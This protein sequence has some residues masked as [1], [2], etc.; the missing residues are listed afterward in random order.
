MASVV[1]PLCSVRVNLRF[2][3]AHIDSN[4]ALHAIAMSSKQSRSQS[5]LRQYFSAK[6]RKR[7]TAIDEQ[8][9]PPRKRFKKQK[10]FA[11]TLQSFE[12]Q[13]D[14]C[15]RLS[16]CD[17]S[18]DSMTAQCVFVDVR[19]VGQKF[20]S[21]KSFGTEQSDDDAKASDSSSDSLSL[22]HEADNKFDANACAVLRNAENASN[23]AD[24]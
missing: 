11:A 7:E 14:R 21:K 17:L 10:P 12:C 24:N 22:F 16:S 19:I 2:I 1:C 6:K 23:D 15:C 13:N 8:I 18:A 20:C 9:E 5:D 3:N 4:C